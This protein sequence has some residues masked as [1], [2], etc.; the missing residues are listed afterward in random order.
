MLAKSKKSKGKEQAKAI[1]SGVFVVEDLGAA[2]LEQLLSIS[3]QG[4]HSLFAI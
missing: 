1:D 3:D 4:M 2:Y